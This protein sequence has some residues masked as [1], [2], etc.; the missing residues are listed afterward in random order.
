MYRLAHY[1][2][3]NG[4]SFGGKKNTKLNQDTIGLLN[5]KNLANKRINLDLIIKKYKGASE[6]SIEFAKSIR[7]SDIQLQQGQ[8]YLQAYE[9]QLNKTGFSLKNV[10]KSALSGLKTL[11]AGVINALGGMAI[12]AVVSGGISLIQK[13]INK[14]KEWLEERQKAID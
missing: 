4:F 1:D 5:D 8:T 6:S 3:E 14:D 7:K 11:G 12:G 13:A 9:A 2:T 10:A